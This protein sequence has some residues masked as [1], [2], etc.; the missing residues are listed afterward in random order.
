[1]IPRARNRIALRTILLML[2]LR[3][4][5]PIIAWM[6]VPVFPKVVTEMDI[7]TA[8]MRVPSMR[9]ASSSIPTP[10]SAIHSPTLPPSDPRALRR[11]LLLAVVQSL[12]SDMSGTTTEAIVRWSRDMIQPPVP[13]PNRSRW[14][15]APEIAT[16]T[17]SVPKVLCVCSAVPEM[18]SPVVAAHPWPRRTIVSFRRPTNSFMFSITVR[19]TV[20]IQRFYRLARAIGACDTV[21]LHGHVRCMAILFIILLAPMAK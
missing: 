2:A 11:P 18:K 10:F 14:A 12:N 7:A 16:A 8:Q 9:P 4:L 13:A 5:P 1:M 17:I 3:A 15:N 19:V 21:C 6:R 20:S